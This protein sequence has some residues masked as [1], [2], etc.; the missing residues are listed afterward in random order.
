MSEDTLVKLLKAPP[1]LARFLPVRIVLRKDENGTLTGLCEDSF[2]MSTMPNFVR[3]WWS[4]KAYS[5][6]GEHNL[7]G[8]KD[9]ERLAKEDDI[10]VDPLSDDCPVVIDWDRW[11]SAT[12]KY[13]QRNAPFKIKGTE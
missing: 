9:A 6:L 12:T 7:S 5:M 11:M 2:A 8:I 4:G 1:G 10:V 13:S 3:I